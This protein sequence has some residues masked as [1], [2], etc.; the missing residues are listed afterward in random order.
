MARSAGAAQRADLRDELR[1]TVEARRELGA[2]YDDLVIEHFLGRL[3]RRAS[4]RRWTER[5]GQ[6]ADVARLLVLL[7][8][9]IPLTWIAAAYV[10]IPGVL[11]VWAVLLLLY[12]RR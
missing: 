5:R 7:S 3:D 10:Q 1:A 8:F 12:Y 9:A 6:L 4:Q 2:D 11:I